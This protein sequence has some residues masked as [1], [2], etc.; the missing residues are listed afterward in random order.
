MD[1][2][3][4]NKEKQTRMMT[5]KKKEKKEGNKWSKKKIRKR[6]NN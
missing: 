1:W 6:W 2:K 3:K 4:T 5:M